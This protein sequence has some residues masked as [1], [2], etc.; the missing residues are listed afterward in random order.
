MAILREYTPERA[1]M[2]RREKNA[3]LKKIIKEFGLETQG[4]GASLDK[5]EI[6]ITIPADKQ[7]EISRRI[8]GYLTSRDWFAIL[9][10]K[11]NA[12]IDYE[13]LNRTASNIMHDFTGGFYVREL[14]L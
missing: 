12:H 11:P 9:G 6:T 13:A 14:A 10:I 7:Q 3:V 5:Q 8:D 2:F 4:I 1:Y